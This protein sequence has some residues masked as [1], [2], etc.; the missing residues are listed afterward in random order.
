MDKMG[1][2]LSPIDVMKMWIRKFLRLA[3]AYYTLWFVTWIIST[4]GGSGPNWHNMKD[5]MQT[6][7]SDWK[8]TLFMVGNIYPVDQTPYSGCFQ[9]S[10][11][12]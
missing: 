9:M 11:P 12:L 2:M 1:R 7:G 10:W 5:N 8:Y 4:R 3:P 6:C